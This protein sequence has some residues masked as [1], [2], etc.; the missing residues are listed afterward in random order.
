MLLLMKII[1]IC[2]I[3]AIVIAWS[4]HV[5][6]NTTEGSPY[7]WCTFE[8]FIEEFNKYVN[9]PELQAGEWGGSSIFL[10]ERVDYGYKGYKETVY[11]HAG[12]VKFDGKCMVL[13]PYS[14]LKYCIWKYI[15]NKKATNKRQK[16][17]WK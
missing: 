6:M 10:R 5:F 13:Y 14:Y 15:F 9:H 8:R 16:G 7:D 11:L 12:I 4:S 2:I 3:L 17:L 1:I